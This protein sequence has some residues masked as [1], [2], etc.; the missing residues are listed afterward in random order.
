MI[1][2][3]FE[4]TLQEGRARVSATVKWE[5]YPFAERQVFFETDEALADDL[6]P[7]PNAFLL[8]AV[9]P[10]SHFGERRIR[11]EGSL[12]P[13]LRDGLVTVVRQLHQWYGGPGD[14]IGIEARDGFEAPAM[15]AALRRA[16]C[17]SGGIDSLDSFRRNRLDFPPDHPASVRDLLFIHGFDLGGNSRFDVNRESYAA[18]RDMLAGFAGRQG[19][20]LLPV[21]TNIRFLE[22]NSPGNYYTGLFVMKSFA[23]CLA[24][25]AHAFPGRLTSLL[26]PSSHEIG[27]LEP[28]GSHPLLDTNYGSSTLAV[29]HDGLIY[30]RMDKTRLLGDWPEGL[31]VLRVCA[32]PTRSDRLINCGRCEKC[33]RTRISLLVIGKL[34]SCPSFEEND[35]AADDIARLW[36]ATP[37]PGASEYGYLGYG[38]NH[39]WG[40]MVE[41]VRALGR[42][43]LVEAIERKLAE[44]YANQNRLGWIKRLRRL[45]RKLLGGAVGRTRYLLRGGRARPAERS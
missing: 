41:P 45:D 28:L 38:S 31:E 36:V 39:F 13:S 21:F 26:I 25:C 18:A 37:G 7:N 43:D 11:V 40:M 17:M 16:C 9:V 32:D 2:S 10:A 33:M 27:D 30:S 44:F 12:C 34:D 1:I 3:E 4:K 19:A 35:V 6:A 14:D 8:A 15:P 23:A 42:R 20:E 22:E 5:D 29:I 24:A